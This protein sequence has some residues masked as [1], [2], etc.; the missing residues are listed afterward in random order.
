[1]AG[2]KPHPIQDAANDAPSLGTRA[3]PAFVHTGVIRDQRATP[4]FVDERHHCLAMLGC[5]TPGDQDQVTVLDLLVAH[6]VALD[7]Q[8]VAGPA[9]EALRGLDPFRVFDSLD[10]MA[11]THP[12]QK[13]QPGHWLAAWVDGFGGR[14]EL[15][16]ATVLDQQL[17][18]RPSIADP[19]RRPDLPD[20]RQH[21]ASAAMRRSAWRQIGR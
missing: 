9:G 21:S 1:V 17:G 16:A 4:A 7:A 10:R 11:G 13:G 14:I 2:T 18:H 15:G 20:R 5:L 19:T 3:S 6:G 8:G 12:P